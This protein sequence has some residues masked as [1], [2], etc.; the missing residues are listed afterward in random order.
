MAE[1]KTWKEKMGYKPDGSVKINKAGIAIIL[2]LV[3]IPLGL[4]MIAVSQSNDGWMDEDSWDD[5][6]EDI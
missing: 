2:A 6:D 1:K 5:A 4:G 3:L